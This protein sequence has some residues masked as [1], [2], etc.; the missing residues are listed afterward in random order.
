MKNFLVEVCPPI[1]H[2][3]AILRLKILFVVYLKFSF[4][5]ASVFSLATLPRSFSQQAEKLRKKNSPWA[6]IHHKTLFKKS[7]YR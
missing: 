2:G 4:N 5:W 1:V 7:V 6:K 3:Q